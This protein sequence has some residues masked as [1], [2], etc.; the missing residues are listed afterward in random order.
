MSTETERLAREAEQHRNRVDETIDSLKQRFSVGQIVDELSGYVR[1]GQ[2]A[3]MVK[4]L[5]RQVRDNP[6][7]LGLVGA[8]IAWLLLGQGVR[9]EGKRLKNQ[10]DDWRDDDE[11]YA[12]S[13]RPSE[14]YP[15]ADG[16][17]HAV[18]SAPIGETSAKGSTTS[19]HSD[20]GASGSP[21][22][23]GFTDRARG[24]ASSVSDAASSAAGSVSGAASSAASGV[25]D[26]ARAA[27]STL[28]DA[29]S[30]TSDTVT[31]SIH[32]ARDAAYDAGD[33]LYRGGAN[34][35]EQVA[36]YG[37]RARRSF[38]DTLQEEPLIVGAVALALGAAV[39]AALPRTQ[40]EDELFGEARDRLRD[41]A[42]EY[43]QEALKKAETIATEAYEAGS[44]EADEKGLKPVG[45]GETIAQKVSSVA[46]KAAGAAK[47]AARKEGLT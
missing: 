45:E 14:G 6:L 16:R 28:S 5:N 34:A 32:D 10:Y 23:P 19:H 27:G 18:G 22:G 39:G 31:R 33:A 7:A 47:D 24:A 35:S 43:G 8:G 12:R 25:S 46:E 1:E 40:R 3:D 44:A 4:N 30:A 38:L 29:A 41:E 26:A 36:R 9:D 21:S 42:L 15:F 17:P 13:R 11:P 20:A 2:G 37:R